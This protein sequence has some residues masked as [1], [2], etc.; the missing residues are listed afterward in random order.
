MTMLRG[1]MRAA[2]LSIPVAFAMGACATTNTGLSSS[3]QRL[4]RSTEVM[5]RNADDNGVR[6]DARSLYEETRD[7]RQTLAD[8]RADRKDVREAFDDLSRSYHALRDEVEDSR[9]RETERDF[10]SVTSAY[11][12]IEREINRSDRYA[13]D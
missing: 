10:D 3:A 2:W 9:D 4:E 8:S 6:K 1:R 12:D 13:R 7:F 5:A 11:L